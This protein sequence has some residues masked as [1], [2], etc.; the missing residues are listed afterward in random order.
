L[1]ILST[2]AFDPMAGTYDAD[3]THTPIGQALRD[4][5]WSRLERTFRPAQRI[6]DIGCGT[7]EDAL[8]LANAGAFVV[9]TDASSQMIQVARKKASAANPSGRVEFRCVPM[10]DIGSQLEGEV[11]DGVLSNFGAVNCAQDLPALVANVAARLR[12]GAPLVWVVMGRYVPWEWMWYL[13]RGDWR[14]AWRR[15]QPEG[16]RWRGVVIRYPTPAQMKAL[17]RPHF[18]IRR[19]APLGVALPPS[20]A[21]GWLSRS[22]RALRYLTCLERLA[23]NLSPLASC[24]DHY[25]V[26][27]VRLPAERVA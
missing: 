2:P 13:V 12:P 15:F 9:G 7:G 14:R 22:P 24:A 4:V 21:A 10:E 6:L 18:A 17:L 23:Q 3:F 25:I 19:V 16:V 27:A 11:F 20:Y 8:R 5:V 26:E 1:P